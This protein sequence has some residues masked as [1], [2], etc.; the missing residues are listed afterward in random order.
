MNGD[1]DEAQTVWDV[2]TSLG[3]GKWD[4]GNNRKT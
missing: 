1:M 3:W 4:D 2:R